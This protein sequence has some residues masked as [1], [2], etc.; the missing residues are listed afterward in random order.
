MD[1]ELE[2]VVAQI[3]ADLE[4]PT[5]FNRYFWRNQR[6]MKAYVRSDEKAIRRL[7]WR[8]P[9]AWMLGVAILVGYPTIAL[10]TLWWL[11]LP[12]LG[13]IAWLVYQ[14]AMVHQSRAI[15]YRAGWLEGR[16]A[17]FLAWREAEHRGMTPED[18]LVAE[19]ERDV[20]VYW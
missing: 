1:P 19:F 13:V 20:Q 17:M 7:R 10:S 11:S 8:L 15:A 14:G 5:L 3:K 9:V 4:R 6:L 18:L 12:A 2:K 16:R